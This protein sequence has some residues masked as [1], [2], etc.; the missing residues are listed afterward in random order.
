MKISEAEKERIRS[1]YK[2]VKEDNRMRPRSMEWLMRET[3]RL[4]K[5]HYEDVH[6]ALIGDKKLG[7]KK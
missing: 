7:D 6:R 4:A 5:C 2:K 1:V 3:Q